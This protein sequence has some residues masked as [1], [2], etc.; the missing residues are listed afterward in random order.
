MEERGFCHDSTSL[1]FIS[2]LGRPA[3]DLSLCAAAVCYRSSMLSTHLSPCKENISFTSKM[4]VTAWHG[5]QTHSGYLTFSLIHFKSPLF[6]TFLTFCHSVTCTFVLS[7]LLHVLCSDFFFF[8][9]R[10]CHHV[11][12]SKSVSKRYGS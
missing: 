5:I 12:D 4:H 9:I 2:F 11:T 7:R 3:P 6:T 10:Q 8:N 1:G